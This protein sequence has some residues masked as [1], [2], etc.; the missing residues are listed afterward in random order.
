[1]TNALA[2]V[3]NISVKACNQPKPDTVCS[4][5]QSES[6]VDKN[7]SK[8]SNLSKFMK[9]LI[10]ILTL[11]AFAIS[12]LMTTEAHAAVKKHAKHHVKHHKKHHK[13]HAKR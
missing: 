5:K 7:N 2:K 9:K 11:A 12:P 6:Q 8:Q 3:D 1:M 4:F 13:R 10:L